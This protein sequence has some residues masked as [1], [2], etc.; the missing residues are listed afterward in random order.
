MPNKYLDSV[1]LGRLITKIKNHVSTSIADL[2]GSAP[3]TLDTLQELATALGNDPNFA[4]T[5]A[6][7]ID[8]KCAQAKAEALL[9]AH[10]V[11]S[12]YWSDNSTSPATLFGGTWQELPAGYTLIAQGSGTDSFGSFTY[13]AGQTYGERMHKLTVGEL[14]KHKHSPGTLRVTGSFNSLIGGNGVFTP[15]AVWANKVTFNGTVEAGTINFDTLNK[16]TGETA[17]TGSDTSHNNVQPSKAAYAW[18]R[19]S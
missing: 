19:I 17:E 15:N 11:G 10:P 3:G 8:T 12:Y 18:V 14:P 6:T 5:I 1:Q 9:A 2:V 4:T 16:W 13:T 7:L